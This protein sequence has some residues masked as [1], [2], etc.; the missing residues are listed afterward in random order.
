MNIKF[1]LIKISPLDHTK[2]DYTTTVFKLLLPGEFII[3]N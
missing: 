3:D 2:V 1:D